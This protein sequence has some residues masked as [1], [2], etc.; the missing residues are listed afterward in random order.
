MKEFRCIVF[1]EQEAIAALVERRRKFRE[2]LPVATIKG[3]SY[4]TS[5]GVNST[6]LMEDDYGKKIPVAIPE[7]EMAAALVNYCLG[8]KIPM[9]MG[10]KKG[11]EVMG[12]D[13]TLLLN[14]A[15]FDMT[16]PRPAKAKPGAPQARPVPART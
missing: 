14:I 9:P 13:V 7:A 10:A 12:S 4:D 8:R 15:D 16:K 6:L 3:L 2:P 11:I 1:N 5:S